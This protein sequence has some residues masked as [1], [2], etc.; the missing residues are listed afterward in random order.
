[1]K[2]LFC[3]FVNCVTVELNAGG[4][5]IPEDAPPPHNSTCISC[6]I[7]KHEKLLVVSDVHNVLGN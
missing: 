4:T 3:L 1:M 6:N 5:C 2:K 7:Q